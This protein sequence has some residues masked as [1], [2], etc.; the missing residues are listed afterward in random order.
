MEDVFQPLYSRE[1][2][3]AEDVPH[4]VKHDRPQW[5]LT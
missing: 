5:M 2:F 1:K 4:E 3:T